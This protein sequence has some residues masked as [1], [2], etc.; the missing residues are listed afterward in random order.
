MKI[1][2]LY[3]F[4]FVCAGSLHA[5][6]LSRLDAPQRNT[7]DSPRTKVMILLG[8]TTEVLL[9]IFIIA[10]VVNHYDKLCFGI[11]QQVKNSYLK[12]DRQ[13][14][15]HQHWGGGGEKRSRTHIDNKTEPLV[16]TAG[17]LRGKYFNRTCCPCRVIW[18][19]YYVDAQRVDY[20]LDLI[21]LDLLNPYTWPRGS[22][23]HRFYPP[24]GAV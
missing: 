2:G 12:H 13:T 23:H 5:V 22:A 1:F 11:W 24:A 4:L 17:Q 20:H 6:S 15:C 16:P 8:S 7:E 9:A 19:P 14:M 18:K 10:N 21:F 3:P